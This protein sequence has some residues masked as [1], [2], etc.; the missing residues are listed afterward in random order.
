MTTR[1]RVELCAEGANTDSVVGISVSSDSDVDDCYR[2]AC[3]ALKHIGDIE[4]LDIRVAREPGPSGEC[5]AG[6]EMVSLKDVLRT[7]LKH[8]KDPSCLL[9]DSFN[10]WSNSKGCT[11]VSIAVKAPSLKQGPTLKQA[12]RSSSGSGASSG[13]LAP[14]AAAASID[15]DAKTRSAMLP[16]VLTYGVFF[17]PEQKIGGQPMKG[18]LILDI[19]RKDL[20]PVRSV[21][22]NGPSTTATLA[23]NH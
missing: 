15:V 11:C 3:N 12:R 7:A 6:S 2:V 5:C 8:A 21:Q 1:V 10:A 17:E 20:S 23:C 13:T 4:S 18:M 22:S 9:P 14:G 16:H 19:H